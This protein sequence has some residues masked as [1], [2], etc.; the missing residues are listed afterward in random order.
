[1]HTFLYVFSIEFD[2][3]LNSNRKQNKDNA[4]CNV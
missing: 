2:G 1:M 3:K 4:I